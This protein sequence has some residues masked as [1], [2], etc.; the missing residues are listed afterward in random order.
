MP[1]HVKLKNIFA[2]KTRHI[3]D[4]NILKEEAEVFK[5]IEIFGQNVSNKLESV[6]KCIKNIYTMIQ[7]TDKISDDKKKNKSLEQEK[8]VV[9]NKLKQAIVAYSVEVDNLNTEL[10][11]VSNLSNFRDSEFDAKVVTP[12]FGNRYSISIRGEDDLKGDSQ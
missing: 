10:N 9:Y 8:A 1:K 12:W 4:G 3:E 11:K 5:N 6:K 2:S 7:K